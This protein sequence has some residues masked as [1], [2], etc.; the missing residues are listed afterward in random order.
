MPR[1]NRTAATLSWSSSME[2]KTPRARMAAVLP[3]MNPSAMRMVHWIS[4]M[5]MAACA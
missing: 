1:H 2:F 5:G 3:A 4:V